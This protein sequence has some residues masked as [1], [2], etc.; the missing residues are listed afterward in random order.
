ME[1]TMTYTGILQYVDIGSGGWKLI[2]DDGQ[3]YDLYGE[4]PQEL[5]N[6]T[7]I[8]KAKPMQGMGLMMGES[9]LSVEQ[10]ETIQ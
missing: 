1:N 9:A 6:K 7:V 3:S 4:I 2:C 10:I 5:N 8:L